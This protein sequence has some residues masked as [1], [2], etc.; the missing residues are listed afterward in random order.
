MDAIISDFARHMVAKQL[1][2]LTDWN[3]P[4][5]HGAHL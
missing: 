4:K 1:M 2:G 5:S 3:L